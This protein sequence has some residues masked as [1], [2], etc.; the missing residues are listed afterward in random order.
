MKLSEMKAKKSGLPDGFSGARAKW[1]DIK[2][3]FQIQKA[4]IL[5]RPARGEDGTPLVYSRGAMEGE[6]IMDRQLALA[7]KTEAG[8]EF[9]VRTNSRRMVSLFSGDLGREPDS[10]N[11]FGDAV[12]IVDA[13]EGWLKFVPFKY[14]YANGQKGD[15]CDLEEA[16]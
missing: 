3:K 12:Y 9:T 15:V 8:D 10:Q 14:E 13:P 5:E 11:A 7:I 6:P 2:Q 4:C 16:E 1:S